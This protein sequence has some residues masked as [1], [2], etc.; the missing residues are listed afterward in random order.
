[1]G[2]NNTATG[3]GALFEN[4]TGTDNT[5][6]GWAAL[7]LNSTGSENTASGVNLLAG[8]PTWSSGTRRPVATA[9]EQR[10]CRKG[11]DDAAQVVHDA[12]LP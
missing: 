5:A 3:Y 4:T 12:M 11:E 2:N 10:R 1:M 7:F 6:T 9:Q 8:N